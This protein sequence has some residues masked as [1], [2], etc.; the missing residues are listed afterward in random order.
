MSSY[1]PILFAD[2]ANILNII[3]KLISFKIALIRKCAKK[4]I[5]FATS[6]KTC[7]RLYIMMI[8]QMK[9]QL[10]PGLLIDNLMYVLPL[11]SQYQISLLFFAVSNI[12]KF[13]TK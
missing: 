2:N 5:T 10:K 13:Q 11:V 9:K 7:I 8:K 1:S 12:G 4:F 3:S 6:D